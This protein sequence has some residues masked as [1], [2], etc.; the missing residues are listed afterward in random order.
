MVTMETRFVSASWCK[1][2]VRIKEPFIA[3]CKAVGLEPTWLD[4][5]SMS[6]EEKD[7][8]KSLPTIMVR[9]GAKPWT[10]YVASEFE[11]WKNDITSLS[12]QSMMKSETF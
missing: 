4:Y 7:T 3:H 5:D 6:E 12:L 8:I 10:H 1:A 11:Y 2:C 9:V